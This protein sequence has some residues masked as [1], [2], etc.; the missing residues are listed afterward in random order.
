[1]VYSSLTPKAIVS[2]WRRDAMYPLSQ[3]ERGKGNGRK[4]VG[5]YWGGDLTG[6][7]I[8]GKILGSS[9]IVGAFG[10]DG[11]SKKRDC[12]HNGKAQKIWGY[13]G[14]TLLKTTP[15]A[16]G[17]TKTFHHLRV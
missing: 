9:K 15:T 1:M 5:F 16:R 4:K 13:D 12:Y 8:R 11:L 14:K 17:S 7:G 10:G 3:G 6:G 2:T